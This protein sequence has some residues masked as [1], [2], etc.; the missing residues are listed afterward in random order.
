MSALDVLGALVL[1]DGR[2]WGESAEPLQLDDARS[3][4]VPEQ[5]GPRRHWLGRA[6]GRS[7]TTDVGGLSLAAM[8]T[9]PADGG[10]PV[11]ARAYAG[12]ADRDQ[13]RLLL[14]AVRGFLLRTPELQ[15]G[16]VDVQAYRI[17]VPQRDI[18]LEVLA[19]DG[20]GAYGLLPDWLA[21]DELCQWPDT[22]NARTV[23]DALTSALPKVATS[24]ALVMTTAGDPGH[25][26]RKVWEHAGSSQL[27]R[28]SDAHGPAPWMSPAEVAD[29][30]RRLMPS[31]FRRLFHNE[32]TAPE[33]RLTTLD[34][35]RDCV[36]TGQPDRLDPVRGVRYALGLDL[37]VTRDNAVLAV[38]HLE[39][40]PGADPRVVCDDLRVWTPVK[41]RPVDLAEV[42]AAVAR[43]S[44]EYGGALVSFDPAKAELMTQRLHRAG[45]KVEQRQFTVGTNNSRAQ[46]LFRLLQ[47]RRLSLP[48]DDQLVDELANVRLLETSPG[49]FRL[50]HDRNRHDDRATALALAAQQLLERAAKPSRKLRTR[51]S[52]ELVDRYPFLLPDLSTEDGRR[53]Q[54]LRDAQREHT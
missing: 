48:D 49:V 30:E 23:Y 21:L 13:A 3:V 40:V 14:D 4:L 50:D 27:W 39:D 19:A 36:R 29:E 25:W 18:V 12:A 33:D 6:R 20:P 7:K 43:L 45:V 5:D 11:G 2:R 15:G 26:S 54:A 46:M 22:A 34:A 38:A 28:V 53:L 10:L 41:G 31:V 32:W 1:A 37:A 17:V 44:G 52:R 8:L 9:E 16:V 35:V 51:H 24:R 42:E 47:N